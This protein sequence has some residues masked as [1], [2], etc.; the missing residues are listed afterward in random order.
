[1]FPWTSMRSAPKSLA[2][3]D[4]TL[5]E[6]ERGQVFHDFVEGSE[7][8]VGLISRVFL[9]GGGT[10]IADVGRLIF[11]EKTTSSLWR[12]PTR[13][14]TGTSPHFAP[15]SAKLRRCRQNQKNV[16]FACSPCH[17]RATSE[18]QSRYRAGNLGHCHPTA[19]VALSRSSSKNTSREY[20]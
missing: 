15:H 5:R 19:E 18:G 17:L 16:P 1:L 2:K 8:D 3:A 7:T 13:R 6:I 14:F 10:V 11:D 9:P 4:L 12:V 20:A